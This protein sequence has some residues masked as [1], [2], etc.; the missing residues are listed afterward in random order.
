M[1]AT[2][3]RLVCLLGVNVVYKFHDELKSMLNNI[4]CMDSCVRKMKEYA[5]TKAE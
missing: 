5:H 3:N 4:G 2:Q 1:S